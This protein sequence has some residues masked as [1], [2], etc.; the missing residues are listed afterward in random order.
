M[1]VRTRP[2]D[3]TKVVVTEDQAQVI[4]DMWRIK[5]GT[6]EAHHAAERQMAPDLEGDR[7]RLASQRGVEPPQSDIEWAVFN[8]RLLEHAGRLD[9][10]LYRNTRFEMAEFL[11]NEERLKAALQ[12]YLEVC[13]IDANGPRNCG[14]ML[15]AGLLAQFPPFDPSTGFQAPGVI[16]RVGQLCKKLSIDE[17]GIWGAYWHGASVLHPSL[18][19]PLDPAEAWVPVRA[20]LVDAGVLE[21]PHA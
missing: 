11:R 1:L 5:N 2:Q 6:Y 14:G 16:K 21:G 12:T 3:S 19:L 20:A 15:D 13:Y 8:K 7:S 17:Q 4:D 9:W 18:H 10:G